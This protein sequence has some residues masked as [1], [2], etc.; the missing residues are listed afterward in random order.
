MEHVKFWVRVTPR[1][2][3][4]W[5]V[6]PY[7]LGMRAETSLQYLHFQSYIIS[8]MSVCACFCFGSYPHHMLVFVRRREDVSY[9]DRLPLIFLFLP[10]FSF[11]L[12]AATWVA[13]CRGDE[14][15]DFHG[16][17]ITARL[18][19]HGDTFMK[20]RSDQVK[21]MNGGD[22]IH[23]TPYPKWRF[24]FS[25]PLEKRREEKRRGKKKIW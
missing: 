22:V 9:I 13:W 16:S 20:H 14:P 3:R 25:T 5:V 2:S 6:Q 12:R 21:R 17:N 15:F 7:I 11:L 23:F 1:S 24:L 19:Q 18:S 8:S 4:K 10:A